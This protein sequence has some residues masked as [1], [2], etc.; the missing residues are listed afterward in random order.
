MHTQPI[1][2]PIARDGGFLDFGHLCINVD[3]ITHFYHDESSHETPYDKEATPTCRISVTG[4][5]M[6]ITIKATI[7][8]ML[9][10]IREDRRGKVTND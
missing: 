10:M 6:E 3:Y 4:L 2:P 8:Q 7:K 5:S 9:D 1:D